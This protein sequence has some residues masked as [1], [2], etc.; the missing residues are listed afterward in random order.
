MKRIY[1]GI[2]ASL[3][4]LYS[5]AQNDFVPGF[6]VK[7]NADTVKGYLGKTIEEELSKQVKF[8][9]DSNG[10]VQVFNPSE[11]AFF[12]L[13]KDRYRTMR[14]ENTSLDKPA[15][16]SCFARQLVGGNYELYTF[17]KD[18]RRFYLV[19]HDTITYLLYNTVYS[20]RAEYEQVGNYMSRLSLLM[21]DC[22]KLRNHYQTVGYDTKD[23]SGFFFELNN[24]L[25]PGSAANYYHKQKLNKEFYV[26]AGGIVLENQI[27]ITASMDLRFSSPNISRKTFLNIG[28]HFSNT[29]SATKVDPRYYRDPRTIIQ[30]LNQVISIP[31]TIQYNFAT[32]RVRPYL[33]GGFSGYHAKEIIGGDNINDPEILESNGFALVFGGGIDIRILTRLY[34]KVEYRYE[35]ASQLPSVGLAYRFK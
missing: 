16:D 22:E 29:V 5:F 17:T 6:I 33:F 12:W 27:Q 2:F 4:S 30:T 14:F 1:I 19:I 24:C 25:A 31:L 23:M 13:D 15:P 20:S 26:Y 34:A 28:L 35:W 7:N 18:E 21:R 10:P 3:I 11:I 9:A 32:G 8:K